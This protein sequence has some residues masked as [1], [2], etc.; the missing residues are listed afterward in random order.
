[1]KKLINP[2]PEMDSN[3]TSPKTDI[4]KYLK[5]IKD[6]MEEWDGIKSNLTGKELESIVNEQA[7][8]TESLSREILRR[9]AEH[10]SLINI[11]Y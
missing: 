6:A 2:K 10:N 1:M 11:N 3:P 9:I 4:N 7:K 5:I 8:F